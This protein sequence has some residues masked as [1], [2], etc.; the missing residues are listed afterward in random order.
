MILALDDFGTRYSTFQLL[1]VFGIKA[2]KIDASLTQGLGGR[3]RDA[4]NQE[5]SFRAVAS[6]AKE[7]NLVTIAEGIE[8]SRQAIVARS[9]GCDYGQGY[10]WGKPEPLGL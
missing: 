5:V 10:L 2:L 3:G 1:N 6:L 4:T 9:L 8:T 7:L